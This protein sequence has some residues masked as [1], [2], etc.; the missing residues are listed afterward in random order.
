V[1]KDV[2]LSANRGNRP[3]SDVRVS[4]D[5][6]DRPSSGVRVEVNPAVPP[7]PTP[8]EAPPSADVIGQHVV[9]SDGAPAG[10]T[11]RHDDRRRRAAP[12]GRAH[13]GERASAAPATA[14]SAATAAAP[15]V[16]APRPH[17][18]AAV[19]AEAKALFEGGDPDKAAPRFEEAARLSP[20]NPAVHRELGK[21]YSRMGQRDR[22]VKEF[23]RYLE[24]APNAS[25]APIYRAIVK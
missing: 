25:D 7:S 13:G 3:G 19:F 8:A 22:S 21:C 20:D 5:A 9:I 16:E 12:S 17:G 14:P 1:N 11:A 4:L 23:R 6:V 18:F 2:R 10:K 15:P 24:L